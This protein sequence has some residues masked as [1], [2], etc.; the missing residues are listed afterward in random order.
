VIAAN[1]VVNSLCITVTAVAT[2][3]AF[4]MGVVVQE[5]FFGVAVL[6]VVAAIAVWLVRR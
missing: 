6:S 3:I 1:N 5:V 2:A 4:A